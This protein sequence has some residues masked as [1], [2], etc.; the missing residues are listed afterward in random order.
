MAQWGVDDEYQIPVTYNAL[1]YHEA[2][3]SH[4]WMRVDLTTFMFAP[5]Y[6]RCGAST[7]ETASLDRSDKPVLEIII[8]NMCTYPNYA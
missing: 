4:P 7:M 1:D 2:I 8:C 6:L 5:E 3:D